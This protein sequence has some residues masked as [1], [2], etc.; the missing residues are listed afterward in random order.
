MSVVPAASLLAAALTWPL[1][2]I[3]WKEAP[4]TA[5][6][7]GLTLLLLL[8]AVVAEYIAGIPTILDRGPLTLFVSLAV[9]Y[10]AALL[11]LS[12]KES[13][14][15]WR[16]LLFGVLGLVPGYHL[17]GYTLMSSVCG[18]QSAGC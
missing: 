2:P 8:V 14:R 12:R 10:G 15:P 13:V 4:A 3:G 9:C 18:L 1:W 5:L 11:F 17:A 6:S 16:L 7:A